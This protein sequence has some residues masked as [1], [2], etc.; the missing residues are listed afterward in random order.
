MTGPVAALQ[1]PYAPLPDDAQPHDVLRYRRNFFRAVKDR[2][3]SAHMSPMEQL[4]RKEISI[5]LASNYDPRPL[6]QV[7]DDV[8]AVIHSQVA[9]R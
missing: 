7:A 1:E 5:Y 9:R 8:R 6:D 2:A 4:V 3:D